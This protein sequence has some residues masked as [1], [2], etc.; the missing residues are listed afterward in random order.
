MHTQVPDRDTEAKDQQQFDEAV[1]RNGKVVLEVLAGV[2]I[3]A[4][5]L[6]SMVALVRSGERS[7]ASAT[8]QPALKQV[9]AATPAAAASSGAAKVSAAKAPGAAKV[10]GLKIVPSYKIGPDGKKHD[11]FTQTEFAVKVGQPLKLRIDNTDNGSHSIT[12][13]EAG[14]NI[15][16]PPGIHTYT[17]LVTKAGRFQW[18]CMIP[19]DS[20][21]NGWAMQNTGFM[22]GYITAT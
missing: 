16:A 6:M 5:L 7:E 4:A 14:V 20:D 13:P 1:K 17:L 8:S 18:Y 15:V 11:A 12:S 22:S 2:G 10:L 9:A 21:A 19:C 3:L